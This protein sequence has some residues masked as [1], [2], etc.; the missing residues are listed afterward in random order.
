MLLLEY[1]DDILVIDAG[2]AFPEEEMLG[3]DIVIPDIT[4]LRENAG[5][6]RGLVVT[7][8]HEDHIGALPFLLQELE[9]PV[10][11]PA[12]AL[13]LLEEKL[14]EYGL[15]LDGSS[16]AVRPGDQVSVGS[17]RVEFFRV[18]HS[19]ADSMGLAVR[20][21]A[22]L[23]VH[24]GDFKFDQTPVDGE[25]ADI[26]RLGELGREGVLCLLCDCTNAER[27]GHVAS[28]KTVGEKLDEIFR[29]AQGRVMVATFASNVHRIQQVI[30]T[31]H[32]YGRR[33]AMVGRSMERTVDV[34]L[35][36]GYLHAPGGC[37][38]GLSEL[39][40]LPAGRV[41]ILTTG[42]QGEPMSAL[43]RISTRSHRTVQLVP[44]D[45]VVIAASPVPGNEK[46]VHR[47]VDNLFRL[48]ARVIYGSESG[49]HVSGH[50]NREEI[51]MM[52]NL[53]RPAY[54]IPVHGEYRHMVAYSRI[55]EEVGLKREQV[56]VAENG[57]I[58][59]FREGKANRVGEAPAGS[60]LVD[61][62]GVG[63]VGN[64]VLRD[65]RQLSEDGIVVVVVCIDA[66]TGDIMSGPD[67]ITRGFVYVRESE[68]LLNEARDRVAR[69]L[70]DKARE[71]IT[72]WSD[73]K[74]TIK[75]A[76]SGYL[77]DRIRRQ[78]MILPIVMDIEGE[79][80]EE[81]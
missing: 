60:I 51:K 8:G 42:S 4:Y 34:A 15:S 54:T 37:L 41:T 64:V 44:G 27:P 17:F 77:Y 70:E 43:T 19:I 21:P 9:V 5:R 13:G 66:R 62:L 65:R 71:G 58:I 26:F 31:S 32:R 11:G 35:E 72:D 39:E 2:L 18:N 6:L 78:P 45:T 74:G 52:L 28:E 16:H 76:I 80:R 69:A 10:Y 68:D 36:L 57:S 22:G 56:I 73:L 30:D 75:Q 61:G 53:T 25:V 24:S 50:G 55:A 33:V 1:R 48:G 59:E 3:I 79:E 14:D 29:H 23:V 20:T 38:A 49:V 63:D 40:R 47:T 81:A 46:L 7:H 67:L 12:L